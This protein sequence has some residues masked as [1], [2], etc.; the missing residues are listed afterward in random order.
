M[1]NYRI[2]C[3]LTLFGMPFMPNER[4]LVEDEYLFS[5]YKRFTENNFKSVTAYNE[6]RIYLGER[7]NRA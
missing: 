6:S 1:Q 4:A 5:D 3:L 2:R 7:Q